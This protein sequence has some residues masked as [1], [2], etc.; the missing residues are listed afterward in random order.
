MDNAIIL[1]D[2]EDNVVG[3]GEKISTHIK[4]YLHRAYSVFIYCKENQKFLLQKRANVKY[5]SSG[6]WSNSFCSHPYRG[7]SWYEA[8]Q[9][10]AYDELNLCLNTKYDFNC[11]SKM[12]P[13]FLCSNLFYAGSFIYHSDYEDIY[14]HEL[15]NVFV[16]EIESI[17]DDILYNKSEVSDIRW[18]SVEEIETCLVKYPND[19][20]SWFEKAFNLVKNNYINIYN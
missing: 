1:I 11:N 10:G 3:Y 14:E 7:E 9:R 13:Q 8:L 17:I 5:H 16:Y 19:Y 4:G 6:K 18:A 12:N 20:S 2:K 15:D